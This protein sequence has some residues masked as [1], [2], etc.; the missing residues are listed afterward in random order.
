M[1][2][3]YISSNSGLLVG[4]LS[5]QSISEL[6][7]SPS[8][9]IINATPSQF[10]SISLLGISSAAGLIAGSVSLQSTSEV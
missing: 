6:A 10:S 3:S 4:S 5:S 8:S 7:P 2:L 1:S 9:S